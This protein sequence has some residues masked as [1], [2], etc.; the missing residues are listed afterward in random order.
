MGYGLWAMGGPCRCSGTAVI[1][2]CG[3]SLYTS[4]M[5]W[6]LSCAKAFAGLRFHTQASGGK[7][8]SVISEEYIS[9]KPFRGEQIFRAG[10]Y[11]R[12]I[13]SR[14][15]KFKGVQ[16]NI[17]CSYHKTEG[18]V[19]HKGDKNSTIRNQALFSL[20]FDTIRWRFWHQGFHNSP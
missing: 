17:R 5:H 14:G 6:F 16:I 11:F 4:D 13:Y 2:S 9:G 1:I 8:F 19:R 7:K 3:I 12:R 18:I 20:A 15:T 10:G